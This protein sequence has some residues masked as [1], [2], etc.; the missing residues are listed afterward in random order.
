MEFRRRKEELGGWDS[1]DANN[2]FCRRIW[3]D[4]VCFDV[5]SA[6]RHSNSHKDWRWQEVEK[7]RDARDDSRFVPSQWETVLLCNGVSHWLGASLEWALDV[8]FATQTLYQQ[9]HKRYSYVNND[10]IH[11]I[12]FHSKVC[13]VQFPP[14]RHALVYQMVTVWQASLRLIEYYLGITF[15]DLE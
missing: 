7:K 3:G 12:V 13:R 5:V 15:N 8:V 1:V 2:E 4:M 10:I 11:A 14:I 6:W 9:V